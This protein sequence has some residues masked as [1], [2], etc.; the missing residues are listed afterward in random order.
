MSEVAVNG[1]SGGGLAAANGL[2]DTGP[3][4]LAASG[5][6]PTRAPGLQLASGSAHPRGGVP[7][8]VLSGRQAAQAAAQQLGLAQGGSVQ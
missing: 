3:S 2:A 6:P 5:R 4:G 8:C 7:L 1:T